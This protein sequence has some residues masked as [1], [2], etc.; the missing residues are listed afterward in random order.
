MSKKTRVISDVIFYYRPVIER[1]NSYAHE[2]QYN[3]EVD[4]ILYYV[5]VFILQ[6]NN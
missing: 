1:Q 4:Y 6:N 2:N 3:I 5:Y